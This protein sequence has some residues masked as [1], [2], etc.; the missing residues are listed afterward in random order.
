MKPL[1]TPLDAGYLACEAVTRAKAKSFHFA[2]AFLPAAKRRDVFALYDFCRHVD[3]LVDERGDRPA[4]AVRADL[5]ALATMLD[6]IEAGRVPADPRWAPL[7]DTIQRRDVP[8][9]PL[10]ELIDGVAGDLGPR[11]FRTTDELLH[12]A[13]QVAGVVG[14]A[15]GPLLGARRTGFEDAGAA[16]GIAMQLTNVLRDVAPDLAAGRRYLP[17]EELARFD[18]TEAD[19]RAGRVDDRWRAFM[20]WQLDRARRYYAE[21]DR[22]V[23]LFPDDGSRLTVRLMQ[24]TYAGILDAIERR[25]HDVFRGRASVGAVGKVRILATAWLADRAPRARV[26]AWRTWP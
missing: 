12:Y 16:L 25:G 5:A 18:L 10:L 7:A 26:P 15:L 20:R 17:D 14:L 9:A 3:D 6:L 4:A 2:A 1:A 11:A 21:G 13:H 22:V 8:I 19:L 24:R 23:P